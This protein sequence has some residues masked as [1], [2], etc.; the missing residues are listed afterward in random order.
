MAFEVNTLPAYV[1]EN[2][3]ILIKDFALVGNGTRARVGV[4]TG[5]KQDAQINYLDIEAVL[6]KAG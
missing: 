5:I 2:R 4:Q 6:Q 3:D 1:Q